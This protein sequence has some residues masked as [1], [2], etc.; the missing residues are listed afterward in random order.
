MKK[1][2]LIIM[3]IATLFVLQLNAQIC[4]PAC[5]PDPTCEEINNPGEI[6]PLIMPTATV[7]EYYDETVTVIP[8]AEYEGLPVI[9]QIRVDDVEN[10][11]PGLDWCKSQ[12]MFEVTDPITR[13]CVQVTGTPTEVG[14][15][16]L[17]LYITPYIDVL[18]NPVEM[19][20][21]TDDTSLSIVVLPPAP[22]A[23]FSANTTNTTTGT[24]V[25]FTDQSTNDPTG[26]AW[27]FE[28][29]IPA[30]SDQQ[31]PTVTYAEE[32]MY[33]VTL[34]VSNEGG[35]DELTEYDYITIDNGTGIN[36]KLQEDVKI[37]PNPASHQITVEAEGLEAV[38]IVDMLGKVVYSEEANSSKEVIDISKLGKANY[39]VKIETVNGEVTKSITIK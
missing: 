2:T 13:Y 36:S 26:W 37:Y 39:F 15:Y 10:L 7:D 30:T 24:E 1:I 14:E 25:E 38:S 4:D 31:N 20:Q 19:S 35:A 3:S 8:P 27:V 29:G 23:E 12:E 11:P 32:G 21:M 6:C 9:Y 28:G 22:I 34:V 18:G 33:D 17:T 5:T 16:Q